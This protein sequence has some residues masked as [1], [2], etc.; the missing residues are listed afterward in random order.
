MSDFMAAF[1]TI[2]G[3]IAIFAIIVVILDTIARRHERHEKR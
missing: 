2:Y 3:G 1:F